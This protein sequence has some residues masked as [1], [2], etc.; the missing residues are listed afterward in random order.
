MAAATWLLVAF[1][2]LTPY[3][4][5]PR[6]A[7]CDRSSA[8]SNEAGCPFTV[9]DYTRQGSRT[10]LVNY[11]QMFY[12]PTG[13]TRAPAGEVHGGGSRVCR[14]FARAPFCLAG[15]HLRAPRVRWGAVDSGARA[16]G[17][18]RRARCHAGSGSTRGAPRSQSARGD[19]ALPGRHRPHATSGARAC[20]CRADR[21]RV[22][23]PQPHGRDRPRAT[24]LLSRRS[25]RARPFTRSLATGH[26]VLA[27]D[28]SAVAAAPRRG[29]GP[30][31]NFRGRRP[32]QA[33]VGVGRGR[34]A[35]S[36]PPRRPGSPPHR[37]A[38]RPNQL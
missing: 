33:G 31:N 37:A 7:W 1:A 27:G 34:H 20:H 12:S 17:A 25:N 14:L 11:E 15:C 6:G 8:V 30:K 16:R 18:P 26:G 29:R 21:G 19:R 36:R 9:N 5:K 38:Q 13:S 4:D 32:Q 23:G 3:P 10:R 2:S 35:E 28:H 24:G 22:G